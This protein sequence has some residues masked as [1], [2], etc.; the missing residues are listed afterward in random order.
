MFSTDYKIRCID[1][2]PD[3][4]SLALGTSEGEIVLYR[5][6]SNYDKIEKVD[7]N[8]QRKSCIRDIK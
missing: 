4:L 2:S 7:S 5:A 6:S 1:F 8:R 3:G